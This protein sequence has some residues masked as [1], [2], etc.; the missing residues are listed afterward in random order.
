MNS[1]ERETTAKRGLGSWYRLAT[2]PLPCCL[3][4]LAAAS[5]AEAQSSLPPVATVTFTPSTVLTGET[6]T[7]TVTVTNPN[8]T[9]VSGIL[10]NVTFSNTY[11]PGFVFDEAIV[12]NSVGGTCGSEA[13]TSGNNTP[14]F[15]PTGFSVFAEEMAAGASCNVVLVLHATSP[16]SFVDTTST[17]LSPAAAEP[18]APAS[19]TLTVAVPVPSLGSWGLIGFGLLLGAASYRAMRRR[20]A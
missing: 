4:L 8:P 11:P 12:S 14:S 7:M 16:G 5:P 10:D 19:A 2:C 13:A 3:F 9:P 18:G 15:T 20:G 17:I 6:T 1:L